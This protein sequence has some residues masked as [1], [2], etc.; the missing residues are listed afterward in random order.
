MQRSDRYVISL[1]PHLHTPFPLFSS[2]I[3]LIVSVD[4]KFTYVSLVRVGSMTS[5]RSVAVPVD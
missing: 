4:F 5:P 1:F 3:S 2:L